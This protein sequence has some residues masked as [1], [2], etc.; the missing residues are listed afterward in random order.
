MKFIFQRNRMH[1]D[2]LLPG[3]SSKVP[4]GSRSIAMHRSLYR[5]GSR[6]TINHSLC[7]INTYCSTVYWNIKCFNEEAIKTSAKH[8]YYSSLLLF[9][10]VLVIYWQI[11]SF[12]W[13]PHNFHRRQMYSR[14]YLIITPIPKLLYMLLV[15]TLL[16]II[17][18]YWIHCPF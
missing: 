15:N 18:I 2:L 10:C 14:K 7:D 16:Q 11:V 1:G 17:Y 12:L 8:C 4:I 6:R 13:T 3:T 5:R 9:R